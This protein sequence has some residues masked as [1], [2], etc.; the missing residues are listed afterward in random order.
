VVSIGPQKSDDTELSDFLDS[1]P[2]GHRRPRFEAIAKAM[3]SVG[4]PICIVE[5]GCMRQSTVDPPETDGC[6]TLVW[7]YIAR[8]TDGSS[9]TIDINPKNIEYAKSKVSEYTQLF[10]ADSVKF[11]SSASFVRKIDFL[12]LDS[13]DWS[14]TLEEKG[15][16]ALHHAAELSAAWPWLN[17]GAVVAIDD[18]HKEYEGKHA[19]V[20]RF[21]DSIGVKPLADDWI[22]VWRKPVPKELVLSF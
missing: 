9:V 7:D 22:H 3:L 12:Y 11:L 17:Y 1:I 10:C 15:L 6:S 8:R 13:M 20:K 2:V 5:T 4:R 19:I 18:C 21:F 16:S 14:G